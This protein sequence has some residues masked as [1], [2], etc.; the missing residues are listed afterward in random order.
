[1]R[2]VRQPSELLLAT[3]DWTVAGLGPYRQQRA[4]RL[5]R[6]RRVS[7]TYAALLTTLTADGPA[8]SMS[9]PFNPGA[10]GI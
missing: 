4:E 8:L 3:G 7:R 10:R 9:V 6:M 2:D 5:G 1:M